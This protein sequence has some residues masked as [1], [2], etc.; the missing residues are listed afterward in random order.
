MK[1]KKININESHYDTGHFFDYEQYQKI[2]KEQP[3]PM[4]PNFGEL[5]FEFYQFGF[6]NGVRVFL[7][8]EQNEADDFV[9]YMNFETDC[10]MCGHIDNCIDIHIKESV[11]R[12]GVEFKQLCEQLSEDKKH[13][14]IY[15]PFKVDSIKNNDALV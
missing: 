5:K 15:C 10:L 2:V 6:K 12:S 1:P 11:K 7:F 4:L 13:C 9:T 8:K 14:V 3:E